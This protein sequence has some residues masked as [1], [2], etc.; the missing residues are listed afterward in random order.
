MDGWRARGK[1]LVTFGL[2]AVALVSLIAATMSAAVTPSSAAIN[3]S[4]NT[5]PLVGATT[6]PIEYQIGC[7]ASMVNDGSLDY[8]KAHGF[9]TVHLVVLDKGTYQNE[10]NKIKSLGMKPIIDIEV[11][12]W[13][14]GQLSGTPISSFASYFQSLKNAGWEYVASEGGR[15]GD[16]EYLSH[17]FKGYVNYN[18]DQCGLWRDMYKHSF[19]VANSWE[20]YYTAEWPSIQQG[21]TAAASLGKQNGILA[22]LWEYGSD[23]VDYN[24][25]LTNSKNGGSP[26][27]KSMLDWSCANGVGFNHFH[28]WCGSNSQGLSRYKALGFEKIVADLQVY[29]PAASAW[30]PVSGQLASGTG[31]AVCSQDANSLDLFVQGTDHALWYRHYQSGSGWSSWKSLSGALTSSP[32]AVSRSAGKIDV[33]VRGTDGALWSRATTN[34]GTSWSNWYKIG[35][36]IL[37]GTGPAVCERGLNSLDVFVQGTDHALWYTHWDGTTWSTWRSLGGGLA[38]SPGVTSQANGKIDVFVRG[39]DGALWYKEYSGSSW[40]SNWIGL[41]GQVAS[42]TG[43]AACS[44][45]A[46]R[47]DVFVQGTD[48]VLWQ[49]TWTGSWSGWQ[50]LGGKLASSPAAATAPGSNRMDVFVRGTDG[51]LWWK[52]IITVY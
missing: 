32:A 25:I 29:Y 37:P 28:V 34:G 21:A 23:G 50:S 48:G 41:G 36:Q 15:A 24:P 4:A 31:P 40:S 9:N 12:I 3:G 6:H 14:G 17:Y 8:F 33:F 39:T 35:G 44:W 13:K 46:G 7:P 30:S 42:G 43:P 27:Y 5:Q 2:L 26:S 38:S 45:G 18:C 1:K 49:K 19:T 20:S 11:P 52:P 22:G 51:A 47:L 16:L 10:L